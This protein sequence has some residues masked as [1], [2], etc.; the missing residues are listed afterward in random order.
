MNRKIYI[1]NWKMNITAKEANSFFNKFLSLHQ[2]SSNRKIIFCPSFTTLASSMQSNLLNSSNEIYFGAQNVSDKKSGAH[3]GEISISMLKEI[4]IDYC[5]VGH[6]ERRTI[7]GESSKVI[8][9]K[10]K[11]LIENNIKPIL[12]IGETLEE[13]ESG[14]SN[15]IVLNQ[16]SVCL[17]EISPSE[18][19]VAY[20]PVWAIGTG[21]NASVNDISTMNTVIKNHMNKLGYINEQFYILYGGSVN[22]SNLSIIDKASFLNG[23][24]I[25]GASLE[26]ENFWNIVRR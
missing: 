9:E 25:G 19:I 1:A 23:F 18:I 16:L 11:L 12:C 20:E 2:K 21:K 6:S 22:I 3:T 5:I 7:Y 10:I 14:N 26:P 8:N 17:K 15:E 24:L 13:R 4:G